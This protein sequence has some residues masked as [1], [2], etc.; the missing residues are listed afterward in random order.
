MYFSYFGVFFDFLSPRPRLGLFAGVGEAISLM[1]IVTLAKAVSL[2]DLSD[3][4]A[5]PA[6]PTSFELG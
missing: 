1:N 6:F 3:F 5:F 2:S 4:S